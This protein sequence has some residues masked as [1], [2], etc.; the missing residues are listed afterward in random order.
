MATVTA[1][2]TALGVIASIIT[3]GIELS[4]DEGVQQ[5]SSQIQK[6]EENGETSSSDTEIPAGSSEAETP[7][8]SSSEAAGTEDVVVE[9]TEDEGASTEVEGTD[10]E[11]ASTEAEGTENKP[12]E[13]AASDEKPA[14]E[15]PAEVSTPNVDEAE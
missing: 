1:I 9:G 3:G 6:A 10:S 8:G 15:K 12:A 11:G 13:E 2:I 4:K 7:A 14:D 5:L